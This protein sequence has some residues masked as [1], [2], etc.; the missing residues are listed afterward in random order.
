[1]KILYL[2]TGANKST[3]A[4][5]MYVSEVDRVKSNVCS[6]S[7][8]ILSTKHIDYLAYYLTRLSSYQLLNCAC[9]TFSY[10]DVSVRLS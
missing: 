2:R 10:W 5:K 7:S 6:T 3:N 4:K 9:S 1:M 8:A